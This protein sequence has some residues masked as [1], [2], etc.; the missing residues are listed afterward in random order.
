MEY[1]LGPW[2]TTLGRM[3]ILSYL[4]PCFMEQSL[5]EAFVARTNRINH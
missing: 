5:G 4:N 2:V 3:S 1:G